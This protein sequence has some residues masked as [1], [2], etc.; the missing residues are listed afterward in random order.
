MIPHGNSMPIYGG[1]D[2]GGGGRHDGALSTEE[3]QMG[4]GE[5][6]VEH[7]VGGQGGQVA[8]RLSP[9]DR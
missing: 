9:R 8:D 1:D 6:D 3:A 4:K 5:T 2:S 7:G